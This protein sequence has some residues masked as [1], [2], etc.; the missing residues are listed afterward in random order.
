MLAVDNE[1]CLWYNDGTMSHSTK[2]SKS[3]LAKALAQ[4]NIKVIHNPALDT[5][6]FD[7]AN[8]TLML[9][10][11][12][13]VSSEV[14]DLL[15]GHEVGHALFTPDIDAGKAADC[16]D[17]PW[18]SVAEDI[19]GNVH[20][21]YVQGLMNII[22]D[23]RIERKVKEKYPGLRRDFSIGYREMFEKNFF[24][25]NDKDVSKMSFGDRLNLHFKVG[26]HLAVPFTAEE[27]EIVDRVEKCDSFDDTCNLTRDVFSFI[28]GTRQHIPMPKQKQDGAGAGMNG[29]QGQDSSQG[30][31]VSQQ[32]NQ[33][34]DGNGTASAASSGNQ[35]TPGQ[36]Q[37]S[38]NDPKNPRNND[39]NGSAPYGAGTGQTFGDLSTQK[40]FDS[41]SQRM[42]NKRVGSTNYYELPVPITKNIIVPY[43]KANS[44]LTN[45]FANYTT[46]YSSAR[47]AKKIMANIDEKYSRLIGT[48]RP[49]IGQLVQQFEM[50]KAADEQKRTTVSRSGRLDTDRL[51]LHKIT[52]DIFMN[53]ATIASGKNHGMVMVIDWSSSMSMVTED[54]LTQVV[55]LSQFCKRMGIPF[56]VYLFTSQY[57]VLTIV[58]NGSYDANKDVVPIQWD[59]HGS[60]TAYSKH[61]NNNDYERSSEAFALIHVLSSD[62]KSLEYTQALKNV[63]TLG[64]FVTRPNDIRSAKDKDGHV[65][66]LHDSLY[67]PVGFNQGNTPLDSTVVA[68]MDIVPKFQAKHKVQIVNTIFLTDGDTGHSVIHTRSYNSEKIYVDCPFNKKQY[69]VTDFPTSTDALLHIFADVTGSNTIGF[70]LCGKHGH[71]RYTDPTADRKEEYKRMMEKGY[72]EAS[73]VRK[74]KVYNYDKGMYEESADAI[75]H[76]YDR[77]FVLPANVNVLDTDEVDDALELLPDNATFTRVRNT[78]FKAVSQRA[79]SRGFINRF[80]DVIAQPVKR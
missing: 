16:T 65:N 49:L 18:T 10:V 24:G 66:F 75:N 47:D 80:A 70:F 3:I 42:V 31:G 29:K 40:N 21:S 20:A 51:C 13:N 19:G 50:K 58:E 11:W 63:F 23:V 61:R 54:V 59:S 32:G 25:T 22:E 79:N 35:G 43:T 74:E 78:F 72:I 55:M 1:Y 39:S 28:G 57:S 69:E 48:T 45:Y 27:Q 41:N 62:M 73:K 44:Y 67:V 17:G 8:R 2:N 53:Y 52:D 46:R 34:Q 71:C 9:P 7:V 76:G 77:L 37:S 33:K 26:V 30:Q 38:G 5:A 68:M 14:Y 60:M 36:G 6:M 4:E 12:E 64:Q 56:D 15:V